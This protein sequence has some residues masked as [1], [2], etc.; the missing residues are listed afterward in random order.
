MHNPYVGFMKRLQ[1]NR[2]QGNFMTHHK[3]SHNLS[4]LSDYKVVIRYHTDI[5]QCYC[6]LL[7][8]YYKIPTRKRI[9]SKMC[10]NTSANYALVGSLFCVFINIAGPPDELYGNNTTL[11]HGDQLL[12]I[13]HS[14]P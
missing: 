6:S 11:Q 12:L 8:A 2:S 1:R 5:K 4:Q 13:S 14:K 7:T 10:D 3:R 9:K